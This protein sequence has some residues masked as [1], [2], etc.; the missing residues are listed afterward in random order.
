[1]TDG[2]TVSALLV[3]YIVEAVASVGGSA[4]RVLEQAEIS[5]RVM[6]DV[7]WPVPYERMVRLWN[8]AETVTGDPIFALHF[9]ERIHPDKTFPCNY[10]FVTSATVGEGLVRLVRYAQMASGGGPFHLAVGASEARVIRRSENPSPHADDFL[11]AF[12]VLRSRQATGV[13]R[14]PTELTFQHRHERGAEELTRFFRCPINFGGPELTMRFPSAVLELPHKTAHPD[15]ALFGL[16]TQFVEDLR[17]SL[18]IEQSA[19]VPVAAAIAKQMSAELPTLSSTAKRLRLTERTLQ[20]RL[21]DGGVTYSQL[22][23]DIRRGLAMR[24]LADPHVNIAQVGF[25]LHFADESAFQRAF[26]RWTRLTPGQY[27]RS[28]GPRESNAA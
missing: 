3:R 27:R 7:D 28:S 15:S 4:E 14:S 22:F 6:T 18:P 17:Q 5:P 19:V 23:D 13:D 11:T 12:I 10:L 16:L 21:A 24:F 25:M 8:L 26:K 9:A 20:R 1:M 2:S